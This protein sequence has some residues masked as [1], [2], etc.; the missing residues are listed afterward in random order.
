M[1]RFTQFTGCALVGVAAFLACGGNEPEPQTQYQAAQAY[2]Q[3]TAYPQQA[4]QA[5]P[6]QYPQQAGQA[7]PQQY[8]QQPGQVY[9][10]ATAYP[11]Q[12]GQAYPQQVP[13]ATPTAVPGLPAGV[14]LPTTNATPGTPA[15]QL[16][17]S[18]GAAAQPIL[19][20]LATTEAPGAT[21]LGSAVVGMFQAGQQIETVVTMQPGKCYTVIATGLPSVTETNVQLVASVPLPG[22]SPVLAQDSTAGPQA[23]VGKAPN[24]YKWALPLPGQVKVIT[25]VAA[26]QGIAA[27]QVYEK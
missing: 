20:Q 4:G 15:Q 19:N 3:A 26:G 13:A 14:T 22:V 7:Y 11:Q 12:P 21:P 10:Q 17:A 25:T 18:A 16:D 6:Q 5:Y 8:P 1:A 24:C 27:T 23:V 9:P 2:P